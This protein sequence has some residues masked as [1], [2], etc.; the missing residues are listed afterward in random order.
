[1]TSR[2]ALPRLSFLLWLIIALGSGV[3][4]AEDGKNSQGSSNSQTS[5]NSSGNHDGESEDAGAVSDHADD[6]AASESAAAA[7]ELSESPEREQEEVARAVASGKAAPL[8]LLLKKLKANFPGQI[9]D[10]ALVR[11]PAPLKFKVKYID[12]TGQVKTVLLNA[13]TLENE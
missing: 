6:V 7:H 5:S 8:P 12:V 1:M 4:W 3:A 9:L 10:V 2:S 13:L 11:V